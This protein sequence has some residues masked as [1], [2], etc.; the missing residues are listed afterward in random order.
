MSIVVGGRE[1]VCDGAH[2]AFVIKRVKGPALRFAIG[3]AT[4]RYIDKQVFRYNNRATK[5]NHLNDADRGMS[6][7]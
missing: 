7:Y 1:G 6:D 5:D 3:R 4:R 2:V